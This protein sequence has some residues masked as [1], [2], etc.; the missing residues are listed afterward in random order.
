M[1]E[2]TFVFTPDNL[3]DNLEKLGAWSSYGLASSALK[4][5]FPEEY[6]EDGYCDTLKECELLG[7]L[8]CNTWQDVIAKYQNEVGYDAPDGFNP[9][10]VN[11]Y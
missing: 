9:L 4:H 11:Q 1:K 10:A 3:L 2:E 6:D 5:Y 7:R 8:G